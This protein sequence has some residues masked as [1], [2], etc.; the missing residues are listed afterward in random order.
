MWGAWSMGGAGLGAE[1]L[2]RVNGVVEGGVA[3]VRGRGL[4]VGAWSGGRGYNCFGVRASWVH[5]RQRRLRLGGR[6]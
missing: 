6:S 4:W 5:L 3:Y 1:V 2:G